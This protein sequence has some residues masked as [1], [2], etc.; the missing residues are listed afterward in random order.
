M[1]DNLGIENGSW[2]L[3][4]ILFTAFLRT[5]IFPLNFISYEATD[6]NKALKPYMDKIRERYA[7][8]QQ[9]M[10]LATAK[11]YE[12]TETNPLAG[13]LPAIA[14]IPVFIALYRSILNLAFEKRIGEGFLWLPNLEGPTYDNGRGLQWLTDNWV[15]GVPPLGWH[16]TLCFLALPAALVVAQSISMKVLSPPPDPNDKAAQNANRVLKYLPLMIGYF[17]ANVPAGLGLYWMTSNVFSVAGSLGAKAYLKQ[18]PPKLDVEFCV[19]TSQCVGC[20]RQFFTKSFLGDDAAVLARS[21][22][23]EPVLPRHRAGVASMAWRTTR[24]FRTNAP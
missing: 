5:L 13:C 15:D 17:S 16:D 3:S 14:Q 21:S 6:R 8:D 4:I 9:S 7:E 20:T 22:D 19:E 11:L 2:G 1:H 10:N 23:G 24:R 12:M 18:N